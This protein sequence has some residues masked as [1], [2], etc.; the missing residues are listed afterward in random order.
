M[1]LALR[2][3]GYRHETGQGAFQLA[4]P[5]DADLA[6]VRAEVELVLLPLTAFPFEEA[7]WATLGPV[8]SLSI[9]EHTLSDPYSYMLLIDA[10][11]QPHLI[12]HLFGQWSFADLGEALAYIQKHHWY[13]ER[14][15]SEE[16]W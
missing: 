2:P 10:Q 9:F 6:A 1:F 15:A 13:G 16:T 7:R 3:D 11:G 8:K 14:A 4:V 12:N 5:P